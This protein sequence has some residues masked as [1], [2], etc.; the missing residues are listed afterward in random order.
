MVTGVGLALL[1]PRRFH[2]LN[3]GYFGWRGLPHTWS[4]RLCIAACLRLGLWFRFVPQ[5]WRILQLFSEE[6]CPGISF[7]CPFECLRKDSV[8]GGWWRWR[9]AG[10]DGGPQS[11]SGRHFLAGF[12][13]F[14]ALGMTWGFYLSFVLF[15]SSINIVSWVSVVALL[16]FRGGF[17]TS[18][19][20]PV[21]VGLGLMTSW[22]E[23]QV[24]IC[25]Q[26]CP[27]GNSS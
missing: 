3:V 1:R 18:C 26:L 8:V 23:L 19:W 11:L 14:L 5:P 25:W 13:G 10:S 9:F 4:Q 22:P 21:M 24:Y 20:F 2:L 27:G 12:F 16:A 15:F 17:M 6:G 7:L